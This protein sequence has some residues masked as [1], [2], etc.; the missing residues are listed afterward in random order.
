MSKFIV[1]DEV[2]AAIERDREA[3]RM[4]DHVAVSM[5]ALCDAI[6]EARRSAATIRGVLG[7]A[8]YRS[9]EDQALVEAA[10]RLAGLP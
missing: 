5:R 7:D 8:G 9:P 6:D 2:R 3:G 1:T 10:E 4:G